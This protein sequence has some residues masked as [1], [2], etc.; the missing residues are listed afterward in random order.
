MTKKAWRP[1]FRA[2]FGHLNS[3]KRYGKY[4]WGYSPL[5]EDSKTLTFFPQ[6]NCFVVPKIWVTQN[7]PKIRPIST[8][9]INNFLIRPIWETNQVL[10]PRRVQY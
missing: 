9:N 8:L 3:V 1:D 6:I 2:K 10:Q 7:I 5:T 4:I